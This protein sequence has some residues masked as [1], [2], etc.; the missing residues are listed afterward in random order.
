MEFTGK[1][2]GQTG[3]TRLLAGRVKIEK[4]GEI[5]F[6]SSEAPRGPHAPGAQQVGQKWPQMNF[7]HFFDLPVQTGLIFRN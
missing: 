4:T 5:G 7:F 3:Y 2:S 6:P 1:F